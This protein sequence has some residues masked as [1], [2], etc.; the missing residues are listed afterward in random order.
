MK[1]YFNLFFILLFISSAYS[2][3]TSLDFKAKYEQ[4]KIDLKNKKFESA[5]NQFLSLKSGARPNHYTPYISYYLALAYFNLNEIQ[6]AEN[7]LITIQN[8]SWS[9]NADLNYLLGIIYLSKKEA[10]KALSRFSKIESKSFE[11]NIDTQIKSYFTKNK[12]ATE[13][14]LLAE[15]YPNIKVLKTFAVENKANIYEL[16]ANEI[17]VLPSRP[18][19]NFSKDIYNIGVLFPFGIDSGQSDNNQYIYDMY[20]GMQFA[21]DKLKSEKINIKL[22]AYEIGNSSEEM[23]KLINNKQFLEDE[24]L[25]GPLHQES[26][27]IAQ[28]YANESKVCLVNPLSKNPQ[29]YRN[30]PFSYLSKASNWGYVKQAQKFASFNFSGESAIVY[31]KNDSLAAR[32]LADELK[33]SNT[34]YAFIKYT[35]GESLNPY[36]KRKFGSIFVFAQPKTSVSLLTVLDKKF[37]IVPIIINREFLPDQ[38]KFSASNNPELYI[39][40]QDFLDESNENLQKFK[41]DFWEKRNN[42]TSLYTYKGYDMMLFWGRQL[43]KYKQNYLDMVTIKPIEDDF[44]VSGFNYG[45]VPNENVAYTITTIQNGVETFYRKF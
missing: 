40:N 21:I 4:A 44:L 16:S 36:L 22:H 38:I 20:E 42:I 10:D 6:S 33:K 32:V 26:N 29:L 13:I 5:K 18:K 19:S 14:K 11:K 12:N 3:S 15:K 9:K 7:Q 39:F 31:E 37:G 25:I 1:Y 23:L 8:T 17:P 30:K 34:K 35:N 24:I 41:S 45:F 2:Q 43:A 28:Y 27:K